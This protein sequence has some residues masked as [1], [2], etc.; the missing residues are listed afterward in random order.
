[1]K[2]INAIIGPCL[3]KKNFEVSEDFKMNFIKT[4][5]HYQ[6]FFSKTKKN[7]KSLFD[8]RSL[9]KYQL[10]SNKI[11]NIDDIIMDTYDNSNFF[12]SHRRSTHLNQLPTGRMINIIGFKE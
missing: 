11:E 10:I 2:K 9:I 5:F 4:N 1:M 7:K 6:K 3:G 12:F 8:M